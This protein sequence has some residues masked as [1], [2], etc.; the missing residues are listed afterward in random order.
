[1]STQDT[2][3]RTAFDEHKTIT[4][5]K[6]NVSNAAKKT[7]SRTKKPKHDIQTQTQKQTNTTKQFQNA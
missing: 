6:H 5:Q 1:M 4:Q 7:K 3:Q 2:A